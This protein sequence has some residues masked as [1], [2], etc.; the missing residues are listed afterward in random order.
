LAKE[1]GAFATRA[2]AARGIR[3]VELGNSRFRMM[4]DTGGAAIVK[5]TRSRLGATCSY[6]VETTPDTA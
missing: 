6:L 2:A 1:L 3:R 4:I 5:R